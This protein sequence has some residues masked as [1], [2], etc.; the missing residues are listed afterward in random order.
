MFNGMKDGAKSFFECGYDIRMKLINKTSLCTRSS[1]GVATILCAA[2]LIDVLP[3]P[4]TDAVAQPMGLPSIGAT[5]GADL[6]PAVE[7][8][9][10]QAIM[11]QGRQDP[12]FINDT[13]ITQY[14]TTMGQRLAAFSPG[15]VPDVHLFAVID[16][17]INAFAMPGGFIGVNSGLVL[18][19]TDESELA[20][21]LSH[22]I[23]HVVQRHIARGMTQQK[24]TGTLALA[25]LA[26]ALLAA[27]AGGG[28]NLAMG[29]AAFGQ[30]AALDR[31]LG[32]SRDAEREADRAGF[33]M[34]SRAGYDPKGMVDMFSMLL[35]ASRLNEGAGGGAWASTHPL[36]IDRLSDIE[37][38]VR[39][40]PPSTYVD[41]PDY[42][43]VRAKLRVIQGRDDGSQ[44]SASEQFTDEAQMQ[45]GVRRAAAQYGLALIAFQK[46]SLTEAQTWLGRA[47]SDGRQ[48]PQLA[49][50]GIDIAAARKDNAA[51]LTI[52]ADAWKRWPGNFAVAIAYVQAL[53]RVGKN[54][55]AESLL[56][57]LAPRWVDAEP[58]FYELLAQS[59]QLAGA[60]VQAGRDRARYY[61]AIGAF[62]AAA[63]Q[64][65]EV[66]DLSTD[67]YEQSQ[68]DVQLK[69]VRDK[70]DEQRQ[71]LER[72][73]IGTQSLS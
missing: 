73:K 45:K 13:D 26:A 63:S 29:V 56:R 7:L 48:A 67:F 61:V 35:N 15:I 55:E 49:V 21:V 16:P 57:T 39:L 46:E 33:Q 28:G 5:S 44:R 70:L 51:A 31:Q 52:A 12:T 6:S 34:M 20:G 30:A 47:Q 24:Q 18:A 40:L 69:E 32:F 38:R 43:F 64:L 17:E 59:E 60:R 66:R 10:G 8:Q 68:I 19:T 58:R 9:L 3:A 53:Q 27:L 36:S 22:E 62:P 25:T 41:S 23:G 71:L 2:L 1:R 14:L 54:A 37:N 42:A 50:L 4:M 72:F 11:A 65:Q